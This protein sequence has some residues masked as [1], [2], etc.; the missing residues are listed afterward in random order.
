LGV[1]M[2]T[3]SIVLPTAFGSNAVSLVLIGS[4]IV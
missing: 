2:G 1:A 3:V 4:Q